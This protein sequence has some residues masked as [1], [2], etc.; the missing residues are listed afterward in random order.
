GIQKFQLP[1]DVIDEGLSNI[2]EEKY[3]DSVR[4]QAA[5][6]WRLMN[7]ESDEFIRRQK[8]ANFLIRRGFESAII[9]RV[10]DKLT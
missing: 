8:T 6:K 3:L 5:K 9:Y 10:I 2:P 1:D 7:S 4:D